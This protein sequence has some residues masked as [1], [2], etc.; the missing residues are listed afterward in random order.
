MNDQ[1]IQLRSGALTSTLFVSKR[2]K[3]IEIK[4][5]RHPLQRRLGLASIHTVNRA[6]PVMHHH[7]HDLPNEAAAEFQMWYMG[8]SREVQTR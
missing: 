1:F 3:M 5:T 7:V 2:E 6:K 8:R 4:I